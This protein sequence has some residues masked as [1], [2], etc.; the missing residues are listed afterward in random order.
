MK[1]VD[2]FPRMCVQDAIIVELFN[3]WI[4][5][6][7]CLLVPKAS[8]MRQVIAREIFLKIGRLTAWEIEE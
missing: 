1:A 6:W 2:N 4:D 8:M 7:M 3:V 5:N